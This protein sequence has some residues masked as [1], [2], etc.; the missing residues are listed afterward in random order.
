M[1]LFLLICFVRHENEADIKA[2]CST[3]VSFDI[4]KCRIHNTEYLH[5]WLKSYKCVDKQ[6]G[7]T[8]VNKNI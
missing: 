5:L 4:G 2:P 1:S 6:L 8:D 7:L 3:P